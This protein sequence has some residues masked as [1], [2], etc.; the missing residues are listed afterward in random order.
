MTQ[1]LITHM[2]AH[3]R[4]HHTQ[5]HKE[6]TQILITHMCAHPRTHTPLLTQNNFYNKFNPHEMTQILF[7]HMRAHHAH[8]T[9]SSHRTASITSS[10]HTRWYTVS[11]L[12][13]ITCALV[14][15]R[16]CRGV[17]VCVDWRGCVWISIWWATYA[18]IH[19]EVSVNKFTPQETTWVQRGVGVCGLACICVNKY[20]F[21]DVCAEVCRGVFLCT[22]NNFYD[23]LSG[24][25]CRGVQRGV[26]LYTRGMWVQRGVR[27]RGLA[28]LRVNTCLQHNFC[29]KFTSH[30]TIPICVS[31]EGCGCVGIGVVVCEQVFTEQVLYRT[32]SVTRSLHMRQYRYVF[33]HIHANLHT[34]TRTHIPPHTRVHTSADVRVLV[35]TERLL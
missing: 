11:T 30:E 4:T 5:R 19:E 20:L 23:K 31:V 13:I 25:V 33:T 1:I 12:C 22:Q 27:V 17:W 24:C 6:M 26:P 15:T 21:V 29:N 3:A 28:W 9:P 10:L 34:H 14:C 7:T 18:H 2:C 8:T 16:E 32:S 35:V